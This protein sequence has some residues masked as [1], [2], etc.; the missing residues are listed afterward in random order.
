MDNNWDQA[1]GDHVDLGDITD[2]DDEDDGL[3]I[4]I[5]LIV[6]DAKNNRQRILDD[7]SVASMK[8]TAEAKMRTPRGWADDEE[9]ETSKDVTMKES[10]TVSTS[11][12]STLSTQ[13][14]NV[15]TMTNEDLETFMRQ[16]SEK[17][18]TT[19]IASPNSDTGEVE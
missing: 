16:A 4:D 3:V 6:L 1:V 10:E 14:F 19:K 17:L 7:E 5:G 13:G 15:N 9:D 18:K 12:P 2:E 11:T 8:S